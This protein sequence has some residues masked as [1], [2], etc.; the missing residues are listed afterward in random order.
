[1]AADVG[2]YNIQVYG[3]APGYFKTLLTKPLYEDKKF[4]SWLRART[5]AIRW[6]DPK[7]RI[8]PTI[9]L[10]SKGSDYVNGHILY[11]DRGLT[12]VCNISVNM[13]ATLQSN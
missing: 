10:A 1:M 2:K 4:D 9:F 6:G 3:L 5:P 11:V 8:G 7:E 13:N 12:A